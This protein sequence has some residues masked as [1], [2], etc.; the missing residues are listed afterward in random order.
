MKKDISKRSWD[1]TG[2]ILTVAA[3][4]RGITGIPKGRKGI[5]HAHTGGYIIITSKTYAQTKGYIRITNKAFAKTKGYIRITNKTFAKTKVY[6]RI[7]GKAC[8]NTSV[9]YAHTM[10][11]VGI[12]G[13]T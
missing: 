9:T 7:T 10:I 3:G 6:I 8:V 4:Y 12:T 1:K 5:T 13:V 11:R 2:K